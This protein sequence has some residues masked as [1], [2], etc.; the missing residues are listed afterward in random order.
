MRVGL[1]PFSNPSHEFGPLCENQCLSE[2][3]RKG[4]KFVF[5]TYQSS[6][7]YEVRILT[8]FGRGD[9]GLN[10]RVDLLTTCYDG[11]L[12][13]YVDVWSR[14]LMNP[15]PLCDLKDVSYVNCLEVIPQKD[16]LSKSL[17]I[18]QL[19]VGDCGNKVHV[20]QFHPTS[21]DAGYGMTKE[22]T[23]ELNDCIYGTRV[24]QNHLVVST[25]RGIYVFVLCVC[26]SFNGRV[27]PI[28]AI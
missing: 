21:D 2:K 27:K 17:R 24:I 28:L 7:V 16:S 15:V 26:L 25:R 14:G 6:P 1:R 11:V 19:I 18:Q 13:R 23:L 5:V 10:L 20:Y 12:L 8:P 9:T 22:R 3:E 4:Q